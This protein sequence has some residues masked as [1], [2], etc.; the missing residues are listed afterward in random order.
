MARSRNSKDWV[1][2]RSVG[3]R[4]A[5]RGVCVW[6]D[7]CH[8]TVAQIKQDILDQRD[9]MKIIKN[10]KLDSWIFKLLVSTVVPLALT[11]GGWIALQAFETNKIVI[12]LDINQQHLL[13]EFAIKPVEK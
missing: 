3:R 8:E 2:N 1:E 6:H 9:D 12:R 5:D 10:S 11:L 13:K 4:E 7:V